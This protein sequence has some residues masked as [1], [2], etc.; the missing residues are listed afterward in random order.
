MVGAR[1]V[2]RGTGGQGG[3]TGRARL[4]EAWRDV[5]SSA[6]AR[7]GRPLGGGQEAGGHEPPGCGVEGVE[8]L[9]QAGWLDSLVA[10]PLADRRPGRWCERGRAVRRVGPGAG[11]GDRGGARLADAET[12]P[13]EDR[14]AGSAGH[15]E[16][17]NGPGRIEGD[18]GR[19]D[20]ARPL[21]QARAW[22]GPTG[23]AGGES[24]AADTR[25]GQRVP[26]VG[27][28]L[29]VQEA[30][31]G[32]RPVGGRAGAW[33][34]KERA[35][36][37]GGAPGA[38]DPEPLVDQPTVEGR[39]SELGQRLVVSRSH[40]ATGGRV[41]GGSQPAMRAWRRWVQGEGAGDQRPRRTAP[42]SGGASRE[43]LPG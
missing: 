19:T 9:N 37:G 2:R 25:P 17:R 10:T 20:P 3:R 8:P 11:A 31:A 42:I 38:R 29:V 16:A 39:G 22:C 33:R 12:G 1:A 23:G 27:D 14:V 40:R 41:G 34:L 4:C 15:A 43:G 32:S 30:G 13:R 24:A 18:D 7:G 6:E 36:L 35:G 5:R 21:A 26:P 28:G